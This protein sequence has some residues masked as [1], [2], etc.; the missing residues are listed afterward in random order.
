MADVKKPPKVPARLKDIKREL[1]SQPAELQNAM[2]SKSTTMLDLNEKIVRKIDSLPKNGMDKFYYDKHD[3]DSRGRPKKKAFVHSCLRKQPQ[4]SC[5]DRVRTDDRVRDVFA[6]IA[7]IQERGLRIQD[8]YKRA[9]TEQIHELTKFEIR[10]LRRVIG[11]EYWETAVIVAGALILDATK[12]ENG[13]AEPKTKDTD[14]LIAKALEIHLNELDATD[15]KNLF[16]YDDSYDQMKQE[17]AQYFVWHFQIVDVRLQIN[18]KFDVADTELIRK[19][20]SK[21]MKMMKSLSTKHCTE[22]KRV[23]KSA[24]AKGKKIE[25]FGIRSVKIAQNKMS[26]R[27]E[28]GNNEDRIENIAE[29]KATQVYARNES[30]KK[31]KARK[32]SSGEAK[33]Q[34]S[35]PGKN[36]RNGNQQSGGASASSPNKSNSNSGKNSNQRSRTP[37]RRAERYRQRSNS[38]SRSRSKQNRNDDRHSQKRES[39]DEDSDDANSQNSRGSK[40]RR[41]RNQNKNKN[42][43][44]GSNG[45]GKGNQGGSRSAGRKK[46]GKKN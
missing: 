22:K 27:L 20:N 31:Q 17:M 44:S 29:K 2:V 4:L 13:G 26:E 12:P 14:I 7:K 35:T 38:R 46:R 16:G 41:S 5:S 40:R 42:K 28:S 39:D 23:K 21:I 37:K 8:E 3:L 25:F 11:C 1:A 15:L 32:K 24:Q 33:N 34:A 45:G 6:E 30:K 9:M 10:A 43:N 18:S 36:G 19:V